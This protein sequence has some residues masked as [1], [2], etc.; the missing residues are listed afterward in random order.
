MIIETEEER[1]AQLREIEQRK[2]TLIQNIA[3]A[4]IA[5]S[6]DEK[7][8]R[9]LSQLSERKLKLFLPRALGSAA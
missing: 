3:K 1:V 4:R 2:R 6:Q 9:E 7:S 5:G 8:I